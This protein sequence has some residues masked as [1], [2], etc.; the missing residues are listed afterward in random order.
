MP[1]SLSIFS[2]DDI[3]AMPQRYRVAFINSLSGF[4]SANLV[5]TQ[6]RAGNTNLSIVSSVFHLGA[7]PALMG[8]IIRPDLSPRHTLDNIR[9]LGVYTLNHVNTDILERAHQT[10]ARYD[11]DTSE[12]DATG[13][14][15][16]WEACEAPFVQE[17]SIRIG[18]VLREEKKLSINGTHLLIGEIT[19]VHVPE[20]LVAD[21]G[22]IDIE[23][24]Q[25]VTVSGLDSYHSTQRRCRLSYAKPGKALSKTP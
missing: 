12:F 24:A 10:S 23:A 3:T 1:A 21:D 5:G 20:D 25:T 11:S 13:L 19:H 4:K 22:Y 8:M 17:A 2:I 7:S 16:L 6:N 18:L 14:T 15:P 9:D